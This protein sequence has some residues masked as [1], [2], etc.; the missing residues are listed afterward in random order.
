M[1]SAKKTPETTSINIS[2]NNNGGTDELNIV[3]LKCDFIHF[4]SSLQF[5]TLSKPDWINKIQKKQEIDNIKKSRMKIAIMFT[6]N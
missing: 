5:N 6:L 2:V 3:L 1:W 4:N